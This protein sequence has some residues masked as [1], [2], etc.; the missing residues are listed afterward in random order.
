MISMVIISKDEPALDETLTLVEEQ[1]RELSEPVETVVVDASAGRLAAVAARHPQVLWLSFTP[2]LAVKVSIPHQRNVGVRSSRGDVIIFTDAGCRPRAGWLIHMV[3]AVREEGE[4]VVAGLAVAPAGSH[5]HYELEVKRVQ[6]A[7][8]LEEAPT[9]NLAFT[10]VAFMAVGGFDERFEYGSD[11]DFSWRLV[12]HGYRIRSLPEAVVE[13]DWGTPRRQVRRAFL[14]GRAKVRLYRKHTVRR[15]Q[16]WRRDPV[17]LAYPAF[18]VGLA[19]TP[20]LPAYPLLLLIPAWRN[21]QYG[22]ASVIVDHLAY[23]AGVLSG[24]LERGTARG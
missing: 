20:L 8:Y 9:L 22:A 17:V 3:A 14:Y 4:E 11:L 23:G 5:S 6:G 19:V 1:A 21:R 12:D 24:W 15:R 18:L 13:H 2:P 16:I 7:R 10:R